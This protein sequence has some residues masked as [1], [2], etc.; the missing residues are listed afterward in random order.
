MK[1]LY[2][3]ANIYTGE[4]FAKAFLVNGDTI[5]EVFYEEIPQIDDCEK[6]NL[7]GQFVCAGF[8]DSHM[9][10]L[11]FG[12]SLRMARLAE[13]TDSLSG[14]MDY[15]K[16]FIKE[17]EFKEGSWIRG[18]GWNQDYFEDVKRMPY[19]ADLDELSADQPIMLTRACGHC[20]VVNSIVLRIANINEDTK[21]PLGGAIDFEHGLL[22]DNAMD[23]VEPFIP[24]PDK[25]EL[26]QMIETGSKA[27]NTFGITSCQS[28]DYCVFREIP[29]EIINE[30]FNELAKEGKLTVRVFE[31]SNFTDLKEFS[32]FVD[33][34]NVTGTGDTMFKIG[35]L[36]LLGDG[37]LGGRTAHLSIPYADDPST[38]GFS[39]FTDEQFD[40]MIAYA[41][42]HDMSVA[43]H[44]IGDACLD[45]VINA[46][47]KA[48]KEY[49]RNDHRHG[50]VHCQISRKDQLQRM[51]D[52]N[53]HIYAQSIFL[54][55][56][57]HI[58]EGRVGKDLASTS[59]SWKT[60]KDGGLCVSNGSDAPVE[61]PDALRG[62][63]CAVTRTS[64][65]GTGPYL[66][67]QAFSVK[68][69]IDSFTIASAEGSFEE[70]YKGLIKEGYL[71]DF[72]ILGKDPFKT[73]PEDI[74]RIP[75]V[76][77]YLNGNCVYR[78]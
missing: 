8:N 31:Q 9:H 30:A 38:Q 68:E 14:M 10:L 18:R 74:H 11:N 78:K 12:Q 42:R 56:D 13:H 69:A 40:K 4:G 65:D 35:P 67:D 29:F 75:V 58:V 22:Y 71:A 64:I 77:T 57:N 59:Y 26:K 28:D 24:L 19:R 44:A 52:L 46:I 2:Y 76:S 33:A 32:R 27:L 55:Y 41:N 15:M 6:V 36:K 1:T 16:H 23:L 70:G 63:E 34:G 45:K 62:I 37:S 5:E 72:V 54:D 3:N 61:L 66:P 43:V 7:N 48:L 39:L 21:A 73:D 50:I 51:I 47:D 20:C 49:P 25:E 60:L 53:V 17:N